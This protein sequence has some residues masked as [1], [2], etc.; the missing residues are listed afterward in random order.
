M[1]GHFGIY[2]G[3][4]VPETLIHPLEELDAAYSAAQSDPA[5]QR[6]L[7]Y[8]FHNYSASP[9]PLCDAER[10]TQAWAAEKPTSRSRA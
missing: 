5:V 6:R 4:F 9:T 2:G 3:Q 8:L 10:L 1:K 7:R